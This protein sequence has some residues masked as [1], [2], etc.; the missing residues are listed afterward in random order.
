MSPGPVLKAQ[1]T[2]AQCPRQEKANVSAQAE[3]TSSPFIAFRS[4]QALSGLD[5]TRPH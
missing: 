2:G 4:V 3:R 1:D 5:D